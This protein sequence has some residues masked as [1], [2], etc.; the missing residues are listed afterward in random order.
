MLRA[1][2]A[3]ALF[4]PIL[5]PAF[6]NKGKFTLL[7][8]EAFQKSRGE[9]D[10]IVIAELYPFEK[11]RPAALDGPNRN[12]FYQEDGGTVHA[13]RAGEREQ[14]ETRV[15][16]LAG[17][18]RERLEELATLRRKTVLL[19]RCASEVRDYAKLI[20]E[21][22]SRLRVRSAARGGLSG[23][24]AAI[25]GA[26][27]GRPHP[28]GLLRPAARPLDG[29]RERAG[30]GGAGAERLPV[31]TRRSGWA[32]RRCNGRRGTPTPRRLRTYRQAAARGAGCPGDVVQRVQEGDQGG[33][34]TPDR[35]RRRGRRQARFGRLYRGRSGGRGVCGPAEAGADRSRLPPITS[36]CTRRTVSRT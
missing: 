18:I 1:A 4:L 33:A 13:S 17:H 14:L 20:A 25:R 6:V 19:T 7:E 28:G 16:M 35:G 34:W 15:A 8:L 3:S 21:G 22:S 29:G 36:C 24:A 9:P 23:R 30:G 27:Q 5:S 11:D 26:V 2:G 31:Q 10:R 12:K 32:F